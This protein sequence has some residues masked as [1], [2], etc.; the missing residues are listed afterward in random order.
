MYV[1]IE[2][3]FMALTSKTRLSRTNF[4]GLIFYRNGTTILNVYNDPEV[5]ET[6]TA[7][8]PHGTTKLTQHK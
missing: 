4:L 7:N 6:I 8:E 3:A 1:R 5:T 2:L